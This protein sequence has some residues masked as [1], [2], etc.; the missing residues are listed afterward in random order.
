MSDIKLFRLTG[1]AATELQGSASD[2]EKSLQMLN[3]RPP[4]RSQ[5]SRKPKDSTHA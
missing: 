2:L 5:L 1:G 3:E 4:A